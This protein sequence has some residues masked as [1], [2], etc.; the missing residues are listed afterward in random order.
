MKEIWANGEWTQIT[1]V[2]KTN[3]N[4]LPNPALNMM[5]VSCHQFTHQ[6]HLGYPLHTWSF[7]KDKDGEYIHS[8][9]IIH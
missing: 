5:E 3:F 7:P 8:V 6:D 4:T 2:L 9:E 1:V